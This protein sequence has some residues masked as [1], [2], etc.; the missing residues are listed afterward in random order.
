MDKK[1]KS[2]VDQGDGEFIL[3][4][5]GT[6]VKTDHV[7]GSMDDRADVAYEKNSEEPFIP[8]IAD[9]QKDNTD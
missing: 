2:L 4:E 1:K 9:E 7:E 5:S 6:S 3:N 8:D